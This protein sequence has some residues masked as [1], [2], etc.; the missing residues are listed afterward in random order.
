MMSLLEPFFSLIEVTVL[1]FENL[2]ELERKLTI[3]NHANRKINQ[4]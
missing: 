3:N 4:I 2:Y 1:L